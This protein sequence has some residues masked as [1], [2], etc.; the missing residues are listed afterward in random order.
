MAYVNNT[1]RFEFPVATQIY[2]AKIIRNATSWAKLVDDMEWLIKE[3]TPGYNP[4]NFRK[5][6]EI[7]KTREDPKRHLTI[8]QHDPENG[9]HKRYVNA[10]DKL[11]NARRAKKEKQNGTESL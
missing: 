4:K 5:L 10:L 11:F 9:Q 3:S 6:L 2:M 7:K 8:I 1:H